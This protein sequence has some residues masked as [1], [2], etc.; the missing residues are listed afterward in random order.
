MA[1][2]INWH[3]YGRKV[4][5][6][7]PMYNVDCVRQSFVGSRCVEPRRRPSVE[8]LHGRGRLMVLA[9]AGGGELAAGTARPRSE[10]RRRRLSRPHTRALVLRRLWR[11]ARDRRH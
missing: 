9:T 3:I 1:A 2:E 8:S 11:T 7:H 4:R 6:C 5:D 10:C